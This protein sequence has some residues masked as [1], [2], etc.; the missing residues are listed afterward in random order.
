SAYVDLQYRTIGYQLG[1]STLKGAGTDNDG[2]LIEESLTY[3]FFNPKVGLTYNLAQTSQVYF[4]FSVANREPV[5]S[6]LINVPEGQE[7]LPEQL[8][9]FELGYRFGSKKLQFEANAY[10][11]Y[12]ID[13]L[14]LTGALN[15]V[16]ANVRQ[17]VDQSYRAGIEL[18]VDWQIIDG[19]SWRPNLTLSQ[20][21]ILSFDQSI[22]NYAPFEITVNTLEN[23]DIAFSPNIIFGSELAANPTNGLEIALLSK[24]VGQ[25]FLDNTSNESRVIDA[26]LVHDARINYDLPIEGVKRVRLGLLVNNL[27]D[28][29]F[30]ANGYTYSYQVGGP[31]ITENYYYPQAGRNFLASLTLEF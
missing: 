1:D 10:Y 17:N 13:Q 25:Q 7:A 26:F 5:R 6:D 4:S 29:L 15:D 16:G 19:L 28:T 12:Y 14:V 9:D 20:N 21:K 11:M 2:Q 3:N 30:A 8:Y 24:Y 22:Y 31:L 27:L 23:T 18:V